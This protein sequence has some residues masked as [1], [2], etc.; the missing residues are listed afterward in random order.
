MNF[1]LEEFKC[2]NSNTREWEREKKLPTN[3]LPLCFEAFPKFHFMIISNETSIEMQREQV[4]AFIL[5]AKIKIKEIKN[6]LCQFMMSEERK[7]NIS[8]YV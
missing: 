2:Q 8:V 5:Y 4:N 3:K 7:N 1:T 6:D